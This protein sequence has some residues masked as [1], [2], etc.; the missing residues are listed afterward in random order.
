MLTWLSSDVLMDWSLG[1]RD[2]KKRRQWM[3]R[4][5]IAFF[6]D[7]PWIY[8]VA[9]V[10]NTVLRFSWVIYLAPHPSAGVQSYIIAL[11]E[12]S[13]RILWAAFRVEAEHIG[14]RDGYRVT[15]DVPLPYVSA[16]S[17][18][19]PGR[20]AV[21]DEDD[22]GPDSGLSRKARFFKRV[23]AVHRNVVENFEPLFDSVFSSKAMGLGRLEDSAEREQRKLEHEARSRRR[24]NHSSDEES[25]VT[26]DEDDPQDVPSVNGG[27]LAGDREKR[28]N[29][30]DRE[31]ERRKRR[32][33][34][35]FVG[36]GDD[37]SSTP[38]TATDSGQLEGDSSPPRGKGKDRRAE[39]SRPKSPLG[40]GRDSSDDAI[41]DNS[42]GDSGSD[43]HGDIGEERLSDQPKKA[44]DPTAPPHRSGPSP[45][46][47][48]DPVEDESLR[49]EI[50][51]AEHMTDIANA[52]TK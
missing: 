13:R 16:N 14:N 24:R 45:S 15:R 51:E 7:M 49:R 41:G 40:V 4:N 31:L 35:I 47:M 46:E 32:R 29:G 5:E 3:L 2:V 37:S 34:S 43:A 33:K 11:V 10:L 21:D 44:D 50:A 26:G 12:A 9:A 17:P 52:N 6:R 1:H 30:A 39:R 18:E 27:S 19:A 38:D 48:D 22:D 36:E 28:P 20:S 25:G 8:Y 42:D 23:H